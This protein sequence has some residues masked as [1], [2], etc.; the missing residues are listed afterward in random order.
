V[1]SQYCSASTVEL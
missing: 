1:F